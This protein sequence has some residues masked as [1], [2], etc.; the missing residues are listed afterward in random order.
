MT[1]IEEFK[2]SLLV[3]NRNFLFFTN[4][5]NVLQIDKYKDLLKKMDVL[6]QNPNFNEVFKQLLNTNPNII[7]V[8]PLLLALSKNEREQLSKNKVFKIIDDFD[9]IKE[10]SFN[11]KITLTDSKIDEYLELFNKTGLKNLFVNILRFS[12]FDYVTGILVGLDSNGRKNRSGNWFEARC[13]QQLKKI[14][15]KYNIHLFSQQNFKKINSIKS[16]HKIGDFM[17]IKN[18][19]ILNIEVNFFLNSGSKPIEIIDSYINRKNE[20]VSKGVNFILITDGPFWKNQDN[21]LNKMNWKVEFFNF[22]QTLS[23]NFKNTLLKMLE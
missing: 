18:E 16:L 12:V 15:L 5:D 3:T 9:F 14:C 17:L 8:F 1:N 4:W 7:S 13:Y 21:L 11:E 20:L 6:I 2:S 19:K 10:Y 22:S 23:Q